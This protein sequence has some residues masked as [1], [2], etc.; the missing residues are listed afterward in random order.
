MRAEII[1]QSDGQSLAYS[2]Y[3][4]G[5]AVLLIHGFTM[6]SEMWLKNGVIDAIFAKNKVIVPDLRGHGKSTKPHDPAMYGATLIRDLVSVLENEREGAAHLIGF[7]TGA[8]LALKLAT[9]EPEKVSSLLLIGSGWSGMDVMPIYREHASW[10]R[11]TGEQMAP[12][13]DYDAMDAL[14]S[15]MPE[16]IDISRD[17]IKSLRIRSAGIAGSED[18]ELP[19]LE[20]LVGVLKGFKLSVLPGVSHET[21]WRDPSLPSRIEGF[22]KAPLRNEAFEV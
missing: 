21:S 19:N 8:E 17:E 1:K 2:V 20:R 14:V 7:S 9:S 3:G 13:P 12:E 10:T 16:I 6:W 22:L 5:P 15:A 18:P 4:E 11:E